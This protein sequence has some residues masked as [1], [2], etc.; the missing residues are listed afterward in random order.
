MD[1]KWERMD[2][3]SNNELKK[4]TNAK[5]TSRPYNIRCRKHTQAPRLELTCSNCDERKPYEDFSNAQR[6]EDADLRR[7]RICVDYTETIDLFQGMSVRSCLPC[8]DSVWLST[9]SSHILP[10]G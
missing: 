10:S 9:D 4:Y 3:F 6:K 8:P 1:K 2:Q 5:R 7:C